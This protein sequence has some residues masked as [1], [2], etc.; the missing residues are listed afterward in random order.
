MT[1]TYEGGCHCRAVRYEVE[2][3]LEQPVMECNCSHCQAKGFL[4]QFVPAD[5]FTLI[6]GEEVLTEY[7][8]NTHKIAHRS[9]SRCAVQCFGQGEKDGKPMYAINVRT[10]DN[11]D[12]DTL[13]R[14]QVN[15]KDF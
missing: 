4:L 10:I 9:C 6:S 7:R 3:D 2:L 15:G 12:L 11:I 5:T 13:T 8:F 1:K 14:K